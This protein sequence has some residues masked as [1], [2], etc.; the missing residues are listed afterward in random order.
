MNSFSL[1]SAWRVIQWYERMNSIWLAF[2]TG[3]T[4]GGISCLAVQ[5]GLLASSASPKT[6]SV[7]AFLAAKVI[8]HTILG[9]FLGLVG[10]SLLLTPKL[11]GFVQIGAGIFMLATAARIA[12]LHPIFRYAVI[13]PPR[14]AYKLLRRLSRDDS[15]F[16]P[17]ALGFFTVLMP[18]GVT[19]ATMAI[20]VASGS[21][22]L[23]AGVMGAFILGTSP[24]FFL[25]GSAVTKLLARHA[26]AYV[27]AGIVIIFAL[28]SLNGGIALT[29]SFYTFGNIV[30]AATINID[31]LVSID[32]RDASIG[33][34]GKQHAAID[35]SVAGY[36]STTQILK[37]GVPVRLRLRTD[38]VRGCTRAFTIPDYGV[39][40]SLPQTG[41]EVVEFTPMRS[42]QLAYTCS[43][44]MYGGYFTVIP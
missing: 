7:G 24:I 28:L 21:P 39:V 30:R 18:C 11:M 40:K 14:W 4:T 27:A 34:D 10:S 22:W 44:G 23:G 42:G 15:S 5:G 6:H 29:G 31:D 17:M 13:Q 33:P 32:G 16:A 25:L 37:R 3:L 36:A 19:Q 41:E 1:S 2:L 35:V 26:F 12:N 20:A 8:S 43:M 9:F 38:N